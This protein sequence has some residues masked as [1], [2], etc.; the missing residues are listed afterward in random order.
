MYVSEQ[1]CSSVSSLDVWLLLNF[2][3]QSLPLREGT[4]SFAF[5]KHYSS[6]QVESGARNCCRKTEMTPPATPPCGQV[7]ELVCYRAPHCREPK[8]G[9]RVPTASPGTG[10]MLPP[11][12]RS[13]PPHVH[14]GPDV[15]WSC[16]SSGYKACSPESQTE[17]RKKGQAEHSAQKNAI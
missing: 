6:K 2:S 10:H 4:D 1:L 5:L 14:L 17:G 11:A 13:H 9:G 16:Y 3:R 15:P 7:Y 12:T 8:A